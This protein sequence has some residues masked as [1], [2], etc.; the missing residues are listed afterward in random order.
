MKYEK[1]SI[2]SW[3][4]DL[5]PVT[6]NFAPPAVGTTDNIQNYKEEIWSRLISMF[7]IQPNF[8]DNRL[9]EAAKQI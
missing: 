2:I 4:D 3:G 5:P 9:S 7:G 6:V 8:S 1:A